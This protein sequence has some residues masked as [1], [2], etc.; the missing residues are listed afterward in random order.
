MNQLKQD[1]ILEEEMR[2]KATLPKPS[3]P[4]RSGSKNSSQ[5]V[6]HSKILDKYFQESY[7]P[8]FSG[9]TSPQK[10]IKL[11]KS[12]DQAKN[13]VLDNPISGAKSTEYALKKIGS[14]V[15]E[16]EQHFND[17]STKITITS[18]AQD[19]STQKKTQTSKKASAKVE[20]LE[21][22]QKQKSK[23]SIQPTDQKLSEKKPDEE[24]NAKQTSKH[25]NNHEKYSQK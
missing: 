8:A 3:N 11:L 2:I 9:F 15:K 13:K 6:D 12:N 10:E 23:S 19:E 18:F 22:A 24:V 5:Q 7:Q 17:S 25:S 20:N 1:L 14:N 21:G 4:Q 16:P